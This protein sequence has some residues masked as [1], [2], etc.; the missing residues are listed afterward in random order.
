MSIFGRRLPFSS[1]YNW[2]KTGL[3]PQKNEKHQK[4]WFLTIYSNFTPVSLSCTPN[5]KPLGIIG[6]ISSK[7]MSMPIFSMNIW[8]WTFNMVYLWRHKVGT[9]RI[10]NH[11]GFWIFLKFPTHT[12]IFFIYY[13]YFLIFGDTPVHYWPLGIRSAM[14]WQN[15]SPFPGDIWQINRIIRHFRQFLPPSSSILGIF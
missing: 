11:F 8:I 15:I 14:F 5:A 4:T 10:N 12:P 6:L 2:Y 1:V 3:F 7:P 9:N 13:V